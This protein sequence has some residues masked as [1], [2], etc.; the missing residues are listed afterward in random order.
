MVRDGTDRMWMDERQGSSRQASAASQMTAGP[1]RGARC[2]SGGCGFAQSRRVAGQVGAVLSQIKGSLQREAKTASADPGPSHPPPTCH[3]DQA[4]STR[5]SSLASGRVCVV[6]MRQGSCGRSTASDWPPST[7]G[8][9]APCT[10][11]TGSPR[12]SSQP[13]QPLQ[14]GGRPRPGGQACCLLPTPASA[15]CIPNTQTTDLG[16]MRHQMGRSPEV[17]NRCRARLYMAAVPSRCT[18]AMDPTCSVVVV[19]SLASPRLESL[20]A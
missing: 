7:P 16:R 3:L 6:A 4:P 14:A 18:M 12:H 20:R 19:L 2:W 17:G 8:R 13:S 5:F 15:S 10:P 1:Q 9:Q 11:H